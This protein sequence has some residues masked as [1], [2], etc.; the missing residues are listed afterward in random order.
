MTKARIQTLFP[1]IDEVYDESTKR[2]ATNVINEVVLDAQAMT[3]APTHNGQR[4]RI[5][6]A[7]QVAIQPPTFILFV[8][9]PDLL[10]FSYKRYIENKLRE[11]FGF[12]GTPIH[13][14]ARKREKQ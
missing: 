6:Y 9:D 14:I 8:N 7:S 3:P 10:H 11:A 5:Y 4:L 13:I 1:L 2:I 12:N